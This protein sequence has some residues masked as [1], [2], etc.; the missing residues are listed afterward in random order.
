MLVYAA[1]SDKNASYQPH[2][3]MS[4]LASFDHLNF[5]F[6]EEQFINIFPF[7]MII[8]FICYFL[9]SFTAFSRHKRALDFS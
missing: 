8:I 4:M 5:F 9:N 3:S 7:I 6:Q 2:P 1:P